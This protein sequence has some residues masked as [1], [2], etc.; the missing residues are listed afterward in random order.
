MR[1]VYALIDYCNYKIFLIK[2][3]FVNIIK[4][5]MFFLIC[6]TISLE[7]GSSSMELLIWKYLECLGL[8]VPKCPLDSK[9]AAIASGPA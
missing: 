6:G 8:F 1:K 7:N 2:Y 3:F 9:V 4:V 5:C